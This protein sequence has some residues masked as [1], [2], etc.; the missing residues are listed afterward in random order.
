MHMNL[1]I[2]SGHATTEPTY[3]VDLDRWRLLVATRIDTEPVAG[4]RLDITP[5]YVHP[6]VMAGRAGVF[7]HGTP[8]YVA[9]QIRDML[10]LRGID[11]HTLT[12]RSDEEGSA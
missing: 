9:G 1:A 6:D 4:N 3:D 2:L 7:D 5:V 10:G 11:A 12:T 8:V